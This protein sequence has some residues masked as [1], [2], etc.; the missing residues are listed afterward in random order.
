M[1]NRRIALVVASLLLP[2]C[3]GAAIARPMT[4]EDILGFTSIDE[5]RVSPDGRSAVV[6][7]SR[8]LLDENRFDADLHLVSIADGGPPRR[9]TM[10]GRRE[11]MPRFSPDGARLGFLAARG[12]GETQVWVMALAGGEARAL[13]AHPSA[14]VGF[15]WAPSGARIL[16][17]AEPGPTPGEKE[18][19][20]RG[21]DAWLLGAQWRN[22]RLY[23]ASAL[24][25]KPGESQ[26]LTDGR[27]HVREDAAWSPDGMRIAWVATPTAEED[28]LE[29]ARLQVLDVRSGAVT[30]V[31]GSERASSFAWL[32]EGGGL[33]FVRAFDARGWSRED[34]FAWT[35]GDAA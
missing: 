1:T 3:M 22:Q 27:W 26:T 31:P 4:L 35:P 24:A 7:V 25:G 12:A 18:R 29:E 17:V 34:L 15:D 30:D 32:P 10:A 16:Y 13:T 6:V 11:R 20:E 9:L 8:A 23:V 5:V 33:L 2:A 19:R 14:V 28:A 21:D